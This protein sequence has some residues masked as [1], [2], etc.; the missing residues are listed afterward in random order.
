MSKLSCIIVD[1]EAS[2]R[3]SLQSWVNKYCQELEVLAL[4]ENILDAK[5]A[6]R[7]YSPQLVFLDIEMPHGNAFDLL[8]DLTAINFEIIFVTA[9]SQYAIQALNLSAAHY[10]L[11]PVDIDELVSAV[12]KVR[13]SIA[14]KSVINHTS[15]LIDN[16]KTINAQQQKVVIP[17]MEGFEVVR[18]QEVL[19]MVADDNFVHIHIKNRKSLMACRSLKFYEDQLNDSGFLRIHRGHMI[20]LEHVS[21]YRKGKYAHVTMCDDRELEIAQ[22]KKGLFLERFLS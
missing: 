14:E 6:I 9:Y 3:N 11:K 7:N 1:D 18:L 19:Y 4:C 16:L 13:T 22:S 2:G 5:K 8:E 21:R 20:N 17:L 10:L 12:N 15:I